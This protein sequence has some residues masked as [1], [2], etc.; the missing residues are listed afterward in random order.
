MLACS[1]LFDRNTENITYQKLL[2]GNLHI[3]MH[4]LEKTFEKS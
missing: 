3:E 1:I 2:R 4:L